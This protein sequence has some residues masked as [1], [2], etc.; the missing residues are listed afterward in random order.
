MEY[1]ESEQRKIGEDFAEALNVPRDNSYEDMKVF[2]T[3]FG[4]KSGV[5]IFNLIM[6]FHSKAASDGHVWKF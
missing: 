3:S 2:K 4:K 5:G 6:E 1:T